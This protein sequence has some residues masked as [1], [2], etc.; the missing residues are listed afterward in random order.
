[1]D[2]LAGL[3]VY[4]FGHDTYPQSIGRGF[5]LKY[6]WEHPLNSFGV[7]L[8]TSVN[9][10]GNFTGK[11]AYEI[12][13]GVQAMAGTTFWSKTMLAPNITAC[14]GYGTSPSYSIST[15]FERR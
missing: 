14:T 1:V 9:N 6:G 8:G 7:F 10:F 15:E 11:L 4:P 3:T 13:P 5:S 2:A 12:F